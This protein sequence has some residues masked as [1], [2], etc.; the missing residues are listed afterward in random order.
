MTENN[1]NKWVLLKNENPEDLLHDLS[2]YEK[3]GFKVHP[4]SYNVYIFPGKKQ[5]SMGLLVD[6]PKTTYSILLSKPLE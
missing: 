2:E 4:E 5:A 3:M 6:S 1:L